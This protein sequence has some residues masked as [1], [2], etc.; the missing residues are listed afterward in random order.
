MITDIKQVNDYVFRVVAEDN[1][2]LFKCSD[3][4]YDSLHCDRKSLK[5]HFDQAVA[6][7][8]MIEINGDWFDVMGCF[9]DPR[10]KAAD[11]DPRFIVRGKSYLDVVIE[12][13][14]E[15]LKKYA[16]NILIMSLGNH[17]TAILKH[18]DTNP[19]TRLVTMLRQHNPNI[20]EGLYEGYVQFQIKDSRHKTTSQLFSERFHHGFGGNAPRSKGML[21]SQIIAMQYPDV[22]LYQSGHTHQ[23]FHDPSN[24]RERITKKGRVHESTMHYLK[25]GSYQKKTVGLGYANINGMPRTRL[26]GWFADMELK[27]YNTSRRIDIS[28]KEA[29][30][31]P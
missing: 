3:I 2:K 4:H 23:K 21:H 13:S 22:D 24:V 29:I 6:E 10:T 27:T 8:R 28:F 25:L 7:D 14:Y 19:L 17:E 20:M 18:R 16:D 30:P 5:A 31:V 11:I 15:F 1:V 12:D 9:K 26:G